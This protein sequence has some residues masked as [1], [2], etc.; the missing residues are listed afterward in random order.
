MKKRA[1]HGDGGVRESTLSLAQQLLPWPSAASQR[2]GATWQDERDEL[3][4]E[5]LQVLHPLP[6][7]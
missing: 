7:P 5:L 2:G 6:V 1:S 3:D 4:A